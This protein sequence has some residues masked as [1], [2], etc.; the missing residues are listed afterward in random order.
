MLDSWGVIDD[1]V[2]ISKVKPIEKEFR[3][4]VVG[5]SISTC[6]FYKKN[7]GYDIKHEDPPS[8]ITYLANKIAGLN[9]D[10]FPDTCFTLDL[11][12]SDNK[13][14]VVEL[15]SLSAS[16]VYLCDLNT[17][18]EDLRINHLKELFGSF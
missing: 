15:N 13:P 17:L 2:C 7:C 8:E 16:G 12:L 6:S 18:F 3:F 4:W 9:R 1:L 11:C 14:Y 10:Y 5:D